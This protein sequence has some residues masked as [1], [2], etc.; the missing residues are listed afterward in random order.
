MILYQC[1]INALG[2]DQGDFCPPNFIRLFIQAPFLWYLITIRDLGHRF[3]GFNPY[4]N[5]ETNILDLN[6]ENSLK[7]FSLLCDLIKILCGIGYFDKI[8]D[9]NNKSTVRIENY[10]V[11]D[12]FDLINE[13]YSPNLNNARFL[14]SRLK[15]DEVNDILLTLN[16]NNFILLYENK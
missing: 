3:W 13:D 16:L 15:L 9:S 5:F 10:S 1:K 8:V 14:I 7:Q 6:K 2:L 11:W 12:L 4:L